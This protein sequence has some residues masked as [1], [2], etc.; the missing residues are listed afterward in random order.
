[1]FEVG[2]KVAYS[3]KSVEKVSTGVVVEIK[4]ETTPWDNHVWTTYIIKTAA[5]RLIPRGENSI[6]KIGV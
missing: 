3:T 1:M 6:I 4:E 5:N 2:D